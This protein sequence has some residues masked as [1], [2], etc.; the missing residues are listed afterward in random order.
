MAEKI[1]ITG[2]G[3]VN[4]LANTVDQTW[5]KIINSVSGLG[6]LT[7]FDHTDYLVHVACEVKDFDPT[8]YVDAREV[9]RRDRYELFSAAAVDQALKHSGFQITEENAPRVGMVISAAIGGIQSLED[10]VLEIERG[11]PR[12]ASPFFI[13]LLIPN[14]AAGPSR[15]HILPQSP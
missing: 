10:G 13:P 6:P 5:D 14:G 9:R 12:R 7:L 4:A 15:I 1:V 8:Q 3:A 2:L 11:G